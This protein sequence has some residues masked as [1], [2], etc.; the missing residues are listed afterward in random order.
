M[1]CADY[2]NKQSAKYDRLYVP[3]PYRTRKHCYLCSRHCQFL[4]VKNHR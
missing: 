3:A 2:V 4:T 1:T